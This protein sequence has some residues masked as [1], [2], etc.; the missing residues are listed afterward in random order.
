MRP[1]LSL[2]SLFSRNNFPL[3]LFHLPPPPLA[4][5]GIPV[6]GCRRSSSLEVS[7]PYPLLSLLPPFPRRGPCPMRPY[8]VPPGVVPSMASGVARPVRPRRVQP[9]PW[10]A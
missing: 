10:R 4:L 7:S 9:R 5:G 1:P 8:P 3:P 2:I 6:S